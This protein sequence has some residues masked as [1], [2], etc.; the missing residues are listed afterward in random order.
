L[1]V[2][3]QLQRLKCAELALQAVAPQVHRSVRRIYNRAGK[4]LA[5][6]IQGPYIADLAYLLLIPCEWLAQLALKLLVPEID[7]ISR[8]MY[9]SGAPEA[10]GG[11][12]A[13]DKFCRENL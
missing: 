8:N 10:A 5:H 9:M 13:K 2:N 11:R 4:S 1:Q 7:S 3:A 12:H 6:S